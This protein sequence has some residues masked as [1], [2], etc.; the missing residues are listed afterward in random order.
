MAVAHAYYCAKCKNEQTDPHAAERLA[1]ALG[2]SLW[3]PKDEVTFD[4]PNGALACQ[5]AIDEAEVVICQPPVGNDCS[6]E[7]G[8]A[9][10]TG[11]RVYALGPL[12]G[13]DWMTKIGV[14][15]VDPV[16]LQGPDGASDMVQ[17]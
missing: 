9:I 7:L 8:Y 4:F 12:P 13:D 5:Q 3:K 1:D 15:Y 17:A 2:L 6:W 14:R 10:G 11:K 16:S